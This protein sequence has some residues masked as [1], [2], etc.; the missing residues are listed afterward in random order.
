VQVIAGNVVTAAQAKNLID[1]GC[2]GLRVG[3][4]SGSI[5]ITQEVMACGRP[6]GTAVYQVAK[7]AKEHG[8]PIIADGGVGSVGHIMKAVALGAS[9]VMMG[10]MLAGTTE[11][12]GEYFYADGVRLKKYRGMGS[13]EAMENTDGK[14]SAC[15]RYFQAS[16]DKVKVA[17]GVTGAIADKGS[18]HK[19]MPYLICGM[20]HGLQDI[21]TKSANTLRERMYSG[22]VRFQKRSASAQVEGGI[23]GLHSYEKRLF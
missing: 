19:Y 22:E 16:T 8:V 15:D 9:S 20:Q 10:S 18:V 5:C 11:A 14:G 7:Y 12:P 21:G 4:G 3:M 1:A 13:V 6:Q 23:H 17:Q 2:D